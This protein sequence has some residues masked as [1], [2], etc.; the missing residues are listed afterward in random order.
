ML[1]NYAVEESIRGLSKALELQGTDVLIT[2]SFLRARLTLPYMSGENVLSLKLSAELLGVPSAMMTR[3]FRASTNRPVHTAI[4]VMLPW[5]WKRNPEQI[6][7]SLLHEY[8]HLF[9]TYTDDEV[10]AWDRGWEMAITITPTMWQTR[11]ESLE[12][13]K[14]PNGG[15]KHEPEKVA[16]GIDGSVHAPLKI[17]A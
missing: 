8:G 17:A 5:G 2:S 15:R 3:I 16:G 12:S 9:P 6:Y 1:I 4:L 10:L 7:A 11:V 13:Y 14:I